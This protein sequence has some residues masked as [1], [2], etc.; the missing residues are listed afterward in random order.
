MYNIMSHFP[1]A[2]NCFLFSQTPVSILTVLFHGAVP[3]ESPVGGACFCDPFPEMECNVH[4]GSK[5]GGAEG[6]LLF[7]VAP[8][9]WNRGFSPGFRSISR[10][11]VPLLAPGELPHAQPGAPGGS[12]DL[13]LQP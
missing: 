9:C 13:D 11:S 5:L 8:S 2:L 6:V 4:Q 3:C 10:K 1:C 12:G 7:Q